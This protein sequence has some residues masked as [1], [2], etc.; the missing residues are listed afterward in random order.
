MPAGSIPIIGLTDVNFSK[1]SAIAASVFDFVTTAVVEELLC[2]GLLFTG[3]LIG[4]SG[5]PHATF[6]ACWPAP[7]SSACCTHPPSGSCSRSSSACRSPLKFST[8]TIRIAVVIHIA[9]DLFTDLPDAT[10]RTSGRWY[11]FVLVFFVFVS[12]IVVAVMAWK[13]RLGVPWSGYVP[14]EYLEKITA[15]TC[16]QESMLRE[17]LFRRTTTIYLLHAGPRIDRRVDGCRIPD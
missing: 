16:S 8:N 14:V 17:T 9:F 4:L 13:D 15:M 2:R 11:V 3:L 5:K 12:G 6:K 7:F 10:A 1:S